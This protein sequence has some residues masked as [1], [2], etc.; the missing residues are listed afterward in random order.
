MIFY[1]CEDTDGCVFDCVTKLQE[2]KDIVGGAGGGTITE[3][4]VPVNADTIQRL[5]GNL[6]GYAETLRTFDL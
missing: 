5:L 2:A 6:G 3:L 1:V 4:K